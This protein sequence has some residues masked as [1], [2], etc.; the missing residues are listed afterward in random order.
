MSEVHRFRHNAR[1]IALGNPVFSEAK[2]H[3][4]IALSVEHVGD[5]LLRRMD[6]HQFVN[7]CSCSYLG[8]DVHP[9]LVEGAIEAMRREKTLLLPISRVRIHLNILDRLEQELSDLFGCRCVT[10]LSASAASAAVLPIMASGHLGDGEPP[11]MVFDKFAHFSMNL[12][13]PICADETEVLTCNHNDLDYL[14][15][16]CK[17]YPRVVYVADGVYGM[18][19]KAPIPELLQLQEKYGLYLYFDD[20]HSLSAYGEHGEGYAKACLPEL[21]DRTIIVASLGKGFG[22]AGGV[23]MLGPERHLDVLERFGGPSSWSQCMNVAAIGASQASVRIHRSPELARLQQQLRDNLELFDSLIETPQHKNPFP[24]R[25]ILIGDASK[26]VQR[27][28]EILQQ[29]FYTS[30][31][32]FPIVERNKAALRVMLRANNSPEEVRRFCELVKEVTRED[33]P[34]A[35]E[36]GVY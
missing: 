28:S 16:A 23:I 33:H 25:I 15:D 22:A 35:D 10:A 31:V 24:V 13:K 17:K 32:F 30:A 34:R 11:V 9:D 21:N 29:G 20:S 5:D 27:S 2:E 36:I 14:E 19:G 26:A 1:A 6:E 7:L 12:I 3:Q 4:L 8:L 18:G